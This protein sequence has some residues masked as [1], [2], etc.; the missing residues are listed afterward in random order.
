MGLR[1]ALDELKA[2]FEEYSANGVM[3][4]T[5]F[6]K[7]LVEVQQEPHVSEAEAK[8]LMVALLK[9]PSGPQ[10]HKQDFLDYLF[11]T[12]HNLAINTRIHHDMTCPLSHYFI[13]TGHNSYLTGNQLSSAC[14]EKPVAEALCRGVRVVELDLWPNSETNDISV[15]H[16]RTLTTPVDFKTCLIAIKENAFVKSD[17]PVVVTLEDHLPPELQAKAAKTIADTF[18]SAL[19]YPES[20][21]GMKEFPSPESLRGRILI[22][23]KPPKEYLGAHNTKIPKP[24]EQKIAVEEVKAEKKSIWGQEIFSFKYHEKDV[25]VSTEEGYEEDSSDEES[26]PPERRQ[27]HHISSEYKRL[28]SIQAGKPKGKSLVDALKVE[29]YAKRVSL[30]EPQLTKIAKSNPSAVVQFTHNN[31]LRIYPYG[32]RFDSSNYNP[33]PAWSHGAQMVAANMQGYGR[34]LWVAHGFFRANGACGYVKKPSFLLPKSDGTFVNMYDPVNPLPVKLKLKVKVCTGYGWLEHFGKRSFDKFSPPDFY[35]RV[36][37][38][39]VG[40]DTVMKRTATI[41]D[42][43]VPEWKEEFEFDLRVPELAVLRVEV[44]E[45]NK[46]TRDDFAG[47]TCMPISELKPGYRVLALCDEKGNELEL[48]KLLLHFQLSL[49]T[50]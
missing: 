44:H 10:F 18:G 35:T 45:E 36:G 38:A 11:D 34:Y 41:D 6:H 46:G 25:G 33:I 47:Q 2:L 3:G 27:E 42:N 21:E 49:N 50:C 13:F 5:H 30:S 16:G 17:Y 24:V 19:F 28:I 22:S 40:A 20:A 15:L 48:V 39:G 32:L 9:P 8:T 26:K 12:H 23:T 7:F 4:P 37:I 14:S 29:E 43:W 31:V 1:P